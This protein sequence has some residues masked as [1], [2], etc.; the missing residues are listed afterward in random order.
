MAAPRYGTELVIVDPHAND[1]EKSV[2]A[3]SAINSAKFFDSK[4]VLPNAIA[5]DRRLHGRISQPYF[6]RL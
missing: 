1:L 4:C 6:L 5:T 2:V 3:L